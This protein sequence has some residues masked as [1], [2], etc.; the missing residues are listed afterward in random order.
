M[1]Q[2]LAKTSTTSADIGRALENATEIRD[3]CLFTVRKAVEC[4]LHK[5][6]K[7]LDIK[8]FQPTP[9]QTRIGSFTFTV[10]FFLV[11]LFLAYP[12]PVE[13]LPMI[14]LET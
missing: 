11:A 13:P 8:C 4:A 10:S 3:I 14:G 9:G 12:L 6:K 2:N 1:L 5:V 7:M